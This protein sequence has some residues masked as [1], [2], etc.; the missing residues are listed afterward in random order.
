MKLP[1]L[2]TDWLNRCKPGDLVLVGCYAAGGLQSKLVHY[3]AN[4]ARTIK[5]AQQKLLLV[6]P[7]NNA[8]EE[9][10][11]VTAVDVATKESFVPK[12]RGRPFKNQSV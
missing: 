5:L 11:L 9:C 2:R 3:N 10:W 1:A 8:C 12:K 4:H 7:V 6:D